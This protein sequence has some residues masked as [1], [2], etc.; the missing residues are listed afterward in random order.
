MKQVRWFIAV[1]LSIG[2]TL[3]LVA[4]SKAFA[5]NGGV[6]LALPDTFAAPNQLVNLPI[7]IAGVSDYDIISA[8]IEVHFDSSCLE[9]IELSGTGAITENW[10]MAAVHRSAKRIYFALAGS[11]PLTEDGVLVFLKFRVNPRARENDACDLKFGEVML[12]EGNP[13]SINRDGRFHVRGFQLAGSVRYQGT[14][15]P[16]LNTKLAITGQQSATFATDANGNFNCY[17][18]H[19]GDYLLT[20][21]KFGDQGRAVTPFDA[22]LILQ[23]LVGANILTPYQRIAADVSGD[24]TV[25]AYDASLIMRYAVRLE[26][27]F[28]TMAD[29]LDCWEFVPTIFPIN[30]SNWVH[31]PNSL[32]YQPLE[33]D[34]FNQNFIGIVY[35]DVSQSWTNPAIAPLVVEKISSA[36]L[37]IEYPSQT[38]TDLVSIPILLETSQPIISAELELK[39]DDTRFSLT[40]VTAGELAQGSLICHRREKSSLVIALAGANSIAG[41]G[42]LV[43][44]WF[45]PIG[46][47]DRHQTDWLKLDRAWLN[48]QPIAVATTTSANGHSHVPDRLELSPN[49]PNPFNQGTVFRISIPAIANPAVLLS[50]YNVRGQLVRSLLNDAMP[51]GIYSIYWDGNDEAGNIA[52][53][54]TYFAVLKAGEQVIRQKLMLLR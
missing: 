33:K 51:P 37:Q 5:A 28:P 35:G 16:I 50:I 52:N 43:S 24:S 49:Y 53:S 21:Q 44:L 6:E 7:R 1:F 8:L 4:E 36:R 46:S 17:G 9:F 22:A 39:F 31:R 15:L 19:Y 23:H 26:N 30:D 45:K 54:G 10:Q 25:S 41:S 3:S 13:P 40:A 47:S 32:I 27:K 34:Q 48:D 38:S 11:L 42:T 29:S 12:N 2:L 20:P 14:G 18:L